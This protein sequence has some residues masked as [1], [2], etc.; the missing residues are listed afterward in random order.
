MKKMNQLISLAGLTLLLTFA[1]NS[2]AAPDAP[3][4][5]E[6]MGMQGKKGKQGKHGKMHGEKRQFKMMKEIK[7]LGLSEEQKTQMKTLH[8]SHR[9][10]IDVLR[11]ATRAA[12]DEFFKAMQSGDKSDADLA[13][14]HEKVVAAKSEEMRMRFQHMLQV[15][16]ILTVEQRAKFRGMMHEGPGEE[17]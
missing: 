11:E 1:G 6:E 2:L 5:G 17:D 3:G 10:Q 8:E 12:H 4:G 7:Q 14:L 13:S 9:A 15:R 16:Q